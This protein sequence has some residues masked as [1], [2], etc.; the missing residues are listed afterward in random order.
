MFE[1][2]CPGWNK[3]WDEW[4]TD[5]RLLK[6][7]PENLE[8]QKEVEKDV[9][10]NKGQS[11]EILNGF[12]NQSVVSKNLNCKRILNVFDMLRVRT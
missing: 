11:R 5:E 10:A 4:I 3:T 7:T 6:V 9:Q 8:K 1:L 2:S 12:R